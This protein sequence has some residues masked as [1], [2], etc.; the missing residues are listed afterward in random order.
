MAIRER[1]Q[2]W[3]IDVKVRGERHREQFNGSKA[4]AQLREAEVRAALAAG[5][6]PKAREVLIKTVP[7][8]RKAFYTC[9]EEY[10]EGKATQDHNIRYCD[11]FM[12]FAGKDTPI[13]DISTELLI[14]YKKTLTKKGNGNSTVNSKLSVVSKLLTHFE[15]YFDKK[16]RVPFPKGR[17][18]KRIRIMSDYERDSIFVYIRDVWPREKSKTRSGCP[19]VIDWLD[20][21]TFYLDTGMRPKETRSLTET[22]LGD[23]DCVHLWQTKN[24]EGRTIPLTRRAMEAFKRQELRRRQRGHKTPF[25]FA[26]NNAIQNVWNGIRTYLGLED[27]PEFVAYLC[28]HDCGT[29][30]YKK[31]KDLLLVKEWLGHKNINQTLTYA[32]LFP[33]TLIAAR[34]AIDV[35]RAA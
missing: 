26:T 23:N 6:S 1:G 35:E 16:P 10:W 9:H 28:R 17:K 34:D 18:N 19:E 25:E 12:D 2:G 14:A 30:L 31:T 20:F 11:E 13:T 27:D 7:T 24:T 3:Q 4:E 33:T 22:C 15:D 29:R 21:F 32:K 5:T 8:I